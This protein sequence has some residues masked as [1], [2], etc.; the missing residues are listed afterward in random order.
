M[1]ASLAIFSVQSEK[2]NQGILNN[3]NLVSGYG[4]THELFVVL[5][6]FFV[7]FEFSF[8]SHLANQSVAINCVPHPE[9]FQNGRS[10]KMEA[11]IRIGFGQL[12]NGY[13]I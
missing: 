5:K 6:T 11:A 1:A 3:P 2:R 13:S 10:G 12:G 9:L 8:V 7:L 4:L